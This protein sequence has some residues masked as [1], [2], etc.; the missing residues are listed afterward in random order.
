[1]TILLSQEDLDAYGE[2]TASTEVVS[3]PTVEKGNILL[4]Q[5]DLEQY[6]GVDKT[7][8]LAHID[9]AN[10]PLFQDTESSMG[11]DFMY[12][13]QSTPT[14]VENLALWLTAK[15]PMPGWTY[16][17]SL[18]DEAGDDTFKSVEALYGK[19]FMS[20]SEDE[21]REQLLAYRQANLEREYPVLSKRGDNYE[22]SWSEAVGSFIGMLSTPTSLIPIGKTLPVASA[23]GAGLGFTY[24]ATEGLA[25][26]GEIDTEDTAKYTLG[27]AILSPMM[28]WG[29]RQVV[30][31]FSNIKGR[32]EKKNKVKAANDLLN[33]YESLVYESINKGESSKFLLRKLNQV[34]GLT[35]DE[36][37]EAVKLAERKVHIPTPKEARLYFEAIE[38]VAGKPA[39][40]GGGIEKIFGVVST[41]IKNISVPTWHRIRK[42]EYNQHARLHNNYT[43]IAPFLEHFSK[44]KG[45]EREILMLSLYNGEF[46][47]VE[48][49]LKKQGNTELLVAFK[50]TQHVLNKLHDEAAEAGLTLGYTENYFPRRVKDI[51]G[52]QLHFGEDK[53]NEILK[54]IEEAAVAK[55]ARL[56]KSEQADV[57]N[58]YLLGSRTFSLG[59]YSS[60]K[61][62]RKIQQVTPELLKFYDDPEQA[63]HT[64]IRRVVTET[65]KKKFFGNAW[66]KGGLD[67][68]DVD[69][70]IARFLIEEQRR[71]SL[72]P[73]DL[74]ELGELIQLR[75]GPGEQAPQHWIQNS[76]NI[77]YAQTLGNVKSA[78]T[79]LGDIFLASYKN[80]IKP[81]V[82][83]LLSSKKIKLEDYGFTDIAEEFASRSKTSNF[84]RQTF[85]WGGFTRIDRLGKETLLNSS[86]IKY[87]NLMT[88]PKKTQAFRKK[89]LPAFGD[90]LNEL[91]DNLR[92]GKI[93][94]KQV[95]LLLWHDLSDMQPVSLIE[96]PAAYLKSPDLRA[97]Y[98]LKTF[99]IKQF[100]IMRRDSFQLMKKKET[101]A[102][103]VKN[104]IRYATVFTAGGMTADSI[105]DWMMGRE[106]DIKDSALNTVWKLIGL[107]KYTG[108]R[109]A[110]RPLDTAF[111][112]AKPPINI[113]QQMLNDAWKAV[114]LDSETEPTNKWIKGLPVV[115]TLAYE[116]LYGGK[117]EYKKKQDKERRGFSRGGVVSQMGRLSFNKGGG[118]SLDN[119]SEDR[120]AFPK[121]EGYDYGTI[122]PFRRNKKSGDTEWALPDLL[123]EPLNAVDRAG[124]TLMGEHTYD[125]EEEAVED[126]L[127]SNITGS[128]ARTIPAMIK[129]AAKP[130][131]D[132]D[133]MNM[134]KL[135]VDD[136]L[137]GELVTNTPNVLATIPPLKVKSTSKGLNISSGSNASYLWATKT[138]NSML[139]TGINVDPTIRRRGVA[140]SMYK[141]AIE[142]AEDRGVNLTSDLTLKV[143]ALAVY[144]KLETL[145]YDVRYNKNTTDVKNAE[146]IVTRFSTDDLP[147]VTV[148]TKKKPKINKK[149]R[150]DSLRVSAEGLTESGGFKYKLPT[151]LLDLTIKEK[152][153]P[154][155]PTQWKYTLSR[156]AKKGKIKKEE[157][158]DSRIMGWLDTQ[159][160]NTK[161]ATEDIFSFMQENSPLLKTYT[162]KVQSKA[163]TEWLNNQPLY[164]EKVKLQEEYH[165]KL[166]EVSYL[167]DISNI[168]NLS[169]THTQAVKEAADWMHHVSVEDILNSSYNPPGIE[170]E[171][172]DFLVASPYSIK[173]I[174]R[175]GVNAKLIDDTSSIFHPT[176]KQEAFKQG[177]K[178]TAKKDYIRE[179]VIELVS[180]PSPEKRNSYIA[181]AIIDIVN[182][183]FLSAKEGSNQKEL[184]KNYVDILVSNTKAKGKQD[185]FTY[186]N[187]SELSSLSK[188]AMARTTGDVSAATWDTYAL[189]NT[190]GK[191]VTILVQSKVGSEDRLKKLKD[192][193][194]AVTAQSSTDYIG[195]GK[196]NSTEGIIPFDITGKSGQLN[197]ITSLEHQL[198]L[199]KQHSDGSW[200]GRNVPTKERIKI[201]KELQ[202]RKKEFNDA[203]GIKWE[204]R[205]AYLNTLEGNIYQEP[206]WTGVYGDSP[207]KKGIPQENIFLHIRGNIVEQSSLG[208][209]KGLFINEQQAQPHQ[210]AMANKKNFE[211]LSELLPGNPLKDATG[212]SK[213][214]MGDEV[215]KLIVKRDKIQKAIDKLWNGVE[216]LKKRGKVNQMESA[217]ARVSKIVTPMDKE[218]AELDIKIRRVTGQGETAGIRNILTEALPENLSH[219]KDWTP[220]AMKQAIKYA[221]DN[222][223]NYIVLPIE[224]H[225]IRQIE[226]WGEGERGVMKAIIDRNSIHSPRAYRNIIKKW[227]KDAKPFK[228]EYLDKDKQGDW[229]EEN[230]HKV[231]VLPI[232]DAIRA[233]F[234][235]DGIPA[236]HRGGLV[237]QMTA[238]SLSA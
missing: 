7:Q 133:F 215:V 197:S 143:S 182:N 30:S 144:A 97:L 151:M 120:I 34:L 1:M 36:L 92:A 61:K 127:Y 16:K 148:R 9:E 186:N 22:R 141:K 190:R 202:L 121:E 107:S 237:K 27:G 42:L 118:V 78:V 238:L 165:N 93:D 75:F 179:A 89:W 235:K 131:K 88:D 147:V 187:S 156:W 158:D 225:S 67:S 69:E 12:G 91:V 113:W 38:K 57:I 17:H 55:G 87:S 214:G 19:D 72:K 232:T 210:T 46:K 110:D 109:A 169:P 39:K 40:P 236:Y 178:G 11:R 116:H 152:I 177:N 226:Q 82:Q 216:T 77:L 198:D 24:G 132:A 79:Q 126:I 5:E 85:K 135:K 217:S 205:Q 32:R 117:E 207:L 3:E 129:S 95:R 104:L 56:S 102:E 170:S 220:I 218:I 192:F 157:L 21:R 59:K 138:P 63:L 68:T 209:G 204:D 51:D 111:E 20:K 167:Q 4:S 228:T 73:G 145:G 140:L 112:I 35:Q 119:T 221:I 184:L 81:T 233:G 231:I 43:K 163:D 172:L 99:T 166:V 15:Q 64:Y 62:E 115:G 70:S 201:K 199:I 206:H 193:R 101:R 90:D 189:A 230:L 188:E 86:F 161:L 171:L 14:D 84:M 194:D 150:E 174:D 29:G 124:A 211:N 175:A 176:H 154:V 18:P 53:R 65:E 164:Q 122:L 203:T 223:L 208:K 103:G 83:A 13:F 25:Q 54:L 23:I 2:D 66:E 130:S 139:V 212:Y 200:L 137:E 76:K 222:D 94:N 44:V 105:K 185:S 45:D 146:G 10:D 106:Y 52:L 142:D 159:D 128:S 41:R 213:L 33:T 149:E 6:G 98:M 47:Q 28:I 49:L 155:K 100:D 134:S 60:Y 136:V 160:V 183:K 168:K 71:G 26:E 74:T 50:D 229:T 108:E 234:K 173:V 8:T 227:D 37:L 96:M 31:K 125:S 162:S 123:R 48:S 195:V 180:D 219:K 153:A 224:K 80:G 181:G 114:D 196:L 58:N 191:P